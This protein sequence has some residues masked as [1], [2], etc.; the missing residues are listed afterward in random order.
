MSKFRELPFS[1]RFATMGDTA[2]DVYKA[3]AP[4]GNTTRFGFRRPKG[5]KFST[6]PET[7][8]HQPD[9][10]T[11][12]YLVEV[13]GMG[14]DGILKSI[15]VAKYE[16]L[17]TWNKIAKMLGLMGLVVFV[18]NSHKH[19]FITLAWSSIVEEV[20]YSKRKYGIQEFKSD[21]VQ[22]YRLDW[23]RLV[24]KATFVGSFEEED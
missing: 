9:F 18:W 19:Q 5:I 14:R 16:A 22:Y 12:T 13:V 23:D 21:G 7:L 10:V 2:E 15:K 1:Q 24:E 11:A 6:F 20:N 17:K 3:V 8:R 4:L